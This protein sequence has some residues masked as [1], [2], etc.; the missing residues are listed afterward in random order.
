MDNSNSSTTFADYDTNWRIS[1]N[2]VF[3]LTIGPSG[4]TA[5]PNL[6]LVLEQQ[7]IELSKHD[8]TLVWSCPWIDVVE[9]VPGDPSQLPNKQNGT[10][11]AVSVK[12]PTAIA[13][14]DANT[15][16][17]KT[18]RWKESHHRGNA[19]R[20]S[21]RESTVRTHR[22]VVPTDD[23]E[24]FETT[25]KKIAMV[26]GVDSLKRTISDNHRPSVLLAIGAVIATGAVVAGLILAAL[27][28]DHIIHLHL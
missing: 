25:I 24:K 9:L 18:T 7:G 28:A 23:Q 11:L 14:G 12:A 15:T 2:D 21:H 1:L 13:D 26:T 3:L 20:P 22:F 6:Q 16:T 19:D 10:V 17:S 4:P 5:V 27:S 8:G